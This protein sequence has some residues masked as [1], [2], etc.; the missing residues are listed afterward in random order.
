MELQ[1]IILIS[2]R[3]CDISVR[4][5]QA[6]SL[7]L[8]VYI[9]VKFPLLGTLKDQLD[10]HKTMSFKP[11]GVTEEG[12]RRMNVVILFLTHTLEPECMDMAKWT[13]NHFVPVL[14]KQVTLICSN[15]WLK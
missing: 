4:G 7:S 11:P 10:R 9:R 3:Y 13:P 8:G 6:L 12:E 1:F 5:I 14:E 15:P 2:L